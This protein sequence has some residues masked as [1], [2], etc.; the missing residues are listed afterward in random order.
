MTKPSILVAIVLAMGLLFTPSPGLAQFDDE[1]DAFFSDPEPTKKE[2]VPVEE[3]EPSV[4]K[5]EPTKASVVEP[6]V[7]KEKPTSAPVVEPDIVKEKPTSA[8]VVEPDIVKEE[9]KAQPDEQAERDRKRAEIRQRLRD[10]M[11]QKAA[12]KMAKPTEPDIVKEESV[13]QPDDQAERDRKRAE[14]RQRLRDRMKQKA[15]EKMAKPTEPDVV[16]EKPTVQPKASPAALSKE[17]KL[18]RKRIEMRKRL[19]Q[20]MKNA[21]GGGTGQRRFKK[22]KLTAKKIQQKMTFV[23]SS[24]KTSPTVKRIR[25]SGNEEAIAILDKAVALFDN[26]RTALEAEDLKKADKLLNDAIKEAGKASRMA[27][28]GE[29]DIELEKEDFASH[30]KSIS[31]SLAAIERLV[32]EK[33][34]AKVKGEYK[35]GKAL[36]EEGLKLAEENKYREA[37]K[38]LAQARTLVNDAM[39]KLRDKDTVTMTLEFDSPADEYKYVHDR[40]LSYATLVDVVGKQKKPNKRKKTKIDQFVAESADLMRSAVKLAE[41]DE[42]EEAVK[43]AD[44]ANK[45]IAKGLRLLGVMV[46]E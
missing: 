36:F 27:G 20:K 40:Y 1:D 8:P 19:R 21:T 34:D 2:P 16:K 42:F 24:V 30:K 4:T 37:N 38:K 14:I 39:K 23:E 18:K 11:K 5:E 43:V 13:V 22:P 17:E 15:A 10:K 3:P 9:P 35:D 25:E 44:T 46:F 12:E 45:T 32:K 6:D 7:V 31:N 29:R 26:S 28:K 33:P 41:N